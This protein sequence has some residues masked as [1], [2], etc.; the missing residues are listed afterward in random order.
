VSD[1]PSGSGKGVGNWLWLIPIVYDQT[2]DW[3]ERSKARKPVERI[4]RE[5]FLNEKGDVVKRSGTVGDLEFEVSPGPRK[6]LGGDFFHWVT[7]TRADLPLHD[8]DRVQTFR[9]YTGETT[10]WRGTEWLSSKKGSILWR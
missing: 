7:V 6:D 10:A 8:P 1:K 2:K 9:C 4:F 5:T 3:Y